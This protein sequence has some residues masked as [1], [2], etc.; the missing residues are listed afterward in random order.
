MSKILYA[1]GIEVVSGAMTKISK[2]Q[3]VMDSNMFLATHRK[4]PS[5]SKACSRAYFRKVN[6]LPWS[7]AQPSSE[8]LQRREAFVTK[9]AAVRTRRHDLQSIALD[10][11]NFQA[12]RASVQSSGYAISMTSYLW[13]L[14]KKFDGT[15]PTGSYTF[16][17]T[18]YINNTGSS[19]DW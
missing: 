18:D 15:F 3:H 17:A 6:N 8:D 16:S 13:A 5:S 11:Q 14:L 12:I 1:P 9:A 4:A 2:G 10:V 7:Y 19:K